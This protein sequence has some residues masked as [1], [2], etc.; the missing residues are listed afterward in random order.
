[1]DVPRSMCHVPSWNMDGAR[2]TRVPSWMQPGSTPVPFPLRLGSPR[3]GFTGFHSGCPSPQDTA[4]KLDQVKAKLL[5]R[6]GGGGF[7]GLV[8][9]LRTL[10]SDGNRQL[11]ARELMEVWRGGP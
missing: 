3:P 10:D 1:M 2:S 11:T 8:R 4:S 7:R 9:V 6:S 5:Q